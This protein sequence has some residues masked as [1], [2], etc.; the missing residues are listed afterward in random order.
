M[1]ADLDSVK[2]HFAKV[3]ESPFLASSEKLEKA[4][5]SGYELDNFTSF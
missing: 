3:F 1:K 4:Q 2:N 5:L